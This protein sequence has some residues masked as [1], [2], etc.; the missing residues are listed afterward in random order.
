MGK[1]KGLL[2]E[3]RFALEE[4]QKTLQSLESKLKVASVDKKQEIEYKLIQATFDWLEQ[5]FSEA[6]SSARE[7]AK[8]LLKKLLITH[9]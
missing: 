7:T 3:V 2:D 9:S 6:L 4:N 8:I 5:G 1:Q